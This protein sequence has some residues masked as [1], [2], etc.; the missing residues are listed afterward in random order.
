MSFSP[1]HTGR[2]AMCLLPKKLKSK[3]AQV[4][5]QLV[6]INCSFVSLSLSILFARGY[7]GLEIGFGSTAIWDELVRFRFQTNL[8]HAKWPRSHS[9]QFQ[10]LWEEVHASA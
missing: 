2:R 3:L 4:L 8:S 10:F 6:T 1:P 5:F 7:T 9:R